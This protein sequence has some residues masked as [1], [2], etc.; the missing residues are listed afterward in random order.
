MSGLSPFGACRIL[1]SSSGWISFGAA[2]ED[3]PGVVFDVDETAWANTEALAR[4]T[5]KISP[6]SV[7][8][9]VRGKSAVVMLN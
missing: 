6:T 3:S 9:A 8:L 2:L 7:R 4:A 1:A 5:T